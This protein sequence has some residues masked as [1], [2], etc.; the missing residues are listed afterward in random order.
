MSNVKEA[1]KAIYNSNPK[2]VK[3]N[4]SVAISEKVAGVLEAKKV[5]IAKTIF[6]K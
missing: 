2:T 1:V 3:E 4:L 5:S 6:A